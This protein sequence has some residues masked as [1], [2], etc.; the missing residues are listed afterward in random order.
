MRGYAASS[1]RRAESAQ[2]DRVGHGACRWFTKAT[3]DRSTCV[4]ILM[5]VDMRR[6]EI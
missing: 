3:L 5:P 4:D 2:Y 1:R 6:C